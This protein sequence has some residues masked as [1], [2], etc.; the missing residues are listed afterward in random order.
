METDI[1][2]LYFLFFGNLVAIFMVAGWF[3]K[4]QNNEK[5]MIKMLQT[6]ANMFDTYNEVLK[7]HARKLDELDGKKKK[8]NEKVVH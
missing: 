1:N 5:R 8:S 4:F 7:L 3:I 2:I 6:C